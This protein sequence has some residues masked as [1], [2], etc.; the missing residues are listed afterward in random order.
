MKRGD[1]FRELI[2]AVTTCIHVLSSI[3]NRANL[4]T[5][6]WWR[7]MVARLV[8]NLGVL[9]NYVSISIGGCTDQKRN[10]E[11]LTISTC[12]CHLTTVNR[13]T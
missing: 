1:F 13:T 10:L 3:T 8:L 6:W 2:V 4:A 9:H 7:Q 5:Y 12:S 11:S